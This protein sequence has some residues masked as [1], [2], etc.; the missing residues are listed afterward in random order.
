MIAQTCNHSTQTAEA[1]G[2]LLGLGFFFFLSP[3][4]AISFLT[5]EV[6]GSLA[7]LQLSSLEPRQLSVAEAGGLRGSSVSSRAAVESCWV[8]LRMVRAE[9]QQVRIWFLLLSTFFSLV[10]FVLGVSTG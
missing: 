10:P 1:G 4:A 2:W 3:V 9:C 7:L 6:T 5:V 8:V